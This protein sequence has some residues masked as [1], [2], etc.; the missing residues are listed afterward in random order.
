MIF[1]LYSEARSLEPYVLCLKS[2][3][4]NLFGFG[5]SGLGFRKGKSGDLV[6]WGLGIEL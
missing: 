1:S 4:F 6:I 3:V 5:S 2:C